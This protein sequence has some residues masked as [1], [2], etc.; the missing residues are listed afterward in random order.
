MNIHTA[1]W[2]LNFL[3]IKGSRSHGNVIFFFLHPPVFSLFF[4]SV[5]LLSYLLLTHPENR[6]SPL[7]TPD[8][9]IKG[10]IA[11]MHPDYSCDCLHLH[12]KREPLHGLLHQA[13]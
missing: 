8:P 11:V 13:S 2:S 5:L 4:L 10:T 7:I 6:A 9:Y 1:Q 12:I 3:D